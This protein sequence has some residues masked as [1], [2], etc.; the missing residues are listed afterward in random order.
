M[1]ESATSHFQYEE[2]LV[3]KYHLLTKK[4]NTQKPQENTE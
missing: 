4:E 3:A 1:K 2:L